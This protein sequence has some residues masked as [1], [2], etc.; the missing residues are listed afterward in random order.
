[1]KQVYIT[2]KEIKMSMWGENIRLCIS[3]NQL[4]RISPKFPLKRLN[5]NKA[6]V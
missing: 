1:M 3:S 6:G 5:Q 4:Y 2:W